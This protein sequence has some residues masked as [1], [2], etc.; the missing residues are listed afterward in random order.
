M[1]RN[2]FRLAAAAL[3]VSALSVM[4]AG[5]PALANPLIEAGQTTDLVVHKYIGETW[6][7]KPNNGTVQTAPAG[8]IQGTDI[9]FKLF[10]VEGVDLDTNEGWEAAKA[11]YDCGVSGFTGGTS[12][13]CG[14]NTYTVTPVETKATGADGTVTFTA[15]PVGLYL[16][17][18]DLD[19]PLTTNANA[20]LLTGA[21]PFL[22]T[23][24]MTDPNGPDGDPATTA[25]NNT[26]WMS[27]VHVYP[28]N[29]LTPNDDTIVKAVLDGN[30]NT[31]NQDAYVV[32]QNL[33]YTLQTSI[34][35]YESDNVQ[36]LSGGDIGYYYVGD[37]LSPYV[38][39]ATPAVAPTVVV[40]SATGVNTTLTGCAMGT[41]TAGCD[42]EW[43]L[44]DQAGGGLKIVFTA[45]GLDKLALNNG[46]TVMTTFVV[47]VD[48]VPTTGIVPNTGS[49]I[50]SNQWW[51]A[52]GGTGTP[53]T[54]GDGDTGTPGDTPGG[55]PTTPP[56]VPS[57]EVLSKF[58]DIVIKKTA[59]DG[60]KTLD[61]ATFAVYRASNDGVAGC[62]D[63]DV[64]GHTA[65]ATSGPTVSGL[66]SIPNIQLSDWYNGAQQTV[67]HTYCLVETKSPT[68]YQLLADPVEF[69]L[70]VAGTVT[71]LATAAGVAGQGITIKN[72]EDNLSN[73]LPL[74]GGTGIAALSLGGLALIGGGLGYYAV[75]SRRRRQQA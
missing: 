31:V 3:S 13:T 30:L 54:P 14:T 2:K 52:N 16:V 59:E 43:E 20:D 44:N 26:T 69:D 10:L 23:L 61:G 45:D 18:E 67:L 53:L 68:G 47:E 27:T 48:S 1:S 5:A 6:A 39:P 21:A 50:P 41:P 66:V 35:V 9:A 56:G 12:I 64:D 51:V 72:L 58:G 38:V 65:I 73:S 11:L 71:D 42:Y 70:T 34:N 40:T 17:M 62:T 46:G 36:G 57:N 19:D 60:T 74:T 32:G 7:G 25:D 63:A 8:A 28:K 24:P 33:T 15:Q 37:F 4:A 75:S 29:S 49:F 55:T 22:V